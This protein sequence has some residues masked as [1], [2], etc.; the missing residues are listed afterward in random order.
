MNQTE[1]DRLELGGLSNDEKFC[2]VERYLQQKLIDARRDAEERSSAQ[3]G[4]V[5]P[6][7]GEYDYAVTVSAAAMEY[8]QS[9]LADFQLPWPTEE[10]CEESCRMFRARAGRL[11][12]QLLFRH[13]GRDDPNSVAFDNKSK[14]K[15]RFHLSQL[16]AVVQKDVMPDWQKQEWYAAIR[17]LEAWLDKPRIPVVAFIEVF[18]KALNGSIEISE[19]VGT[20]YGL[21][22][23]TKA[24]EKARA[25]LTAA[26]A[27]KQL[28]GP[29][30]KQLAAP[31]STPAKGGFGR[32]NTGFDK[33]LDDEIPF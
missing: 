19:A 33:A 14:E 18:G 24:L 20:L 7:F 31:K 12:Q 1:I 28:E 6:E 30:T 10:H 17:D 2:K 5:T 16:R 4:N 3:Y 8:G 25:L 13:A 21:V 27:P 26:A 32:P 15:L 23:E 9:D 11:A 29:K 22:K